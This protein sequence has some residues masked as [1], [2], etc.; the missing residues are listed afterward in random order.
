MLKLT[1]G[2]EQTQ[3]RGS[4]GLY[5]IRGRF[6]VITRG[7]G[8]LRTERRRGTWSKSPRKCS[9]AAESVYREAGSSLT[10]SMVGVGSGK[11]LRE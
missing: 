3:V 8:R 4:V 10:Q 9:A 6:G 1:H 2:Q 7:R 5:R 11:V